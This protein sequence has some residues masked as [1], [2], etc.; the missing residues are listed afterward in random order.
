MRLRDRLVVHP[1]KRVTLADWDADETLGFQKA[2]AVEKTEKSIARLD[3]LQYLMYAEHRRALLVLPKGRD[4]GG[5]RGT[6]PD[7][8]RVTWGVRDLVTGRPVPCL[9]APSIPGS[10]TSR[11]RRCSAY[12][13]YC[14]SSRRA[15]LFS[16]FSTAAAFWNPSVSS[17]S[18]SASVTRLSGWTTSLS[19]SLIGRSYCAALSVSIWPKHGDR[20]LGRGPRQDAAL[21]AAGERQLQSTHDVEHLFSRDR[22]WRRALDG[23]AHIFVVVREARRDGRN[24][25][26]SLGRGQLAVP[27]RWLRIPVRFVG[28]ATGFERLFLRIESI[29]DERASRAV[30][31]EG[32]PRRGGQHGGS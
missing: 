15:M 9:P 10:T 6:V 1:D 2:A 18:Q 3:E 11:A 28:R 26:G 17:A 7:L 16:V 25:S 24:G 29:L 12:I 32:R 8:P 20:M 31:D 4:A 5:K 19:R 30:N 21:P 14:S 23:V 27:V 13:R 22:R